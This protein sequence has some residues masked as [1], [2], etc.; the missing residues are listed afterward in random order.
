MGHDA[1][2]LAVTAIRRAGQSTDAES[3]NVSAGAVIQMLYQVRGA[4]SVVGASGEL[5]ISAC[6]DSVG[7]LFPLL[8]LAVDGST[9]LVAPAAAGQPLPC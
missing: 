3:H 7:I 5:S 6:G 1:M 4:N 2:L 8:S 9:Q